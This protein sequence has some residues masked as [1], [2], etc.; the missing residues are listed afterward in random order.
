MMHVPPYPPP[1][2]GGK[3]LKLLAIIHRL[4][5][6]MINEN[7]S[8]EELVTCAEAVKNNYEYVA[9]VRENINS[10]KK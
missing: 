8:P 7:I 4:Q 10:Q 5:A 3:T 2:H 1:Q 9:P 6:I